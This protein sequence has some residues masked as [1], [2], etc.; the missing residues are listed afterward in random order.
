VASER[1]HIEGYINP[2]FE[3]LRIVDNNTGYPD[4]AF[5]IVRSSEEKSITTQ[6][7][8]RNVN[9]TRIAFMG[10]SALKGGILGSGGHT[11]TGS[12]FLPM[13]HV[14]S[15]VQ[16]QRASMM[17]SQVAPE[18]DEFGNRGAK[19]TGFD[20]KERIAYAT[21]IFQNWG[22]TNFNTPASSLGTSNA[23]AFF[24]LDFIKLPG[25]RLGSAPRGKKQDLN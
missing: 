19:A 21:A 25:G 11:V 2:E 18:T 15:I 6:G 16:D 23:Q 8:A 9:Y 14:H 7:F 17:V 10:P 12:E 5:S 3:M 13:L 1:L 22:I 24:R 4:T 20:G